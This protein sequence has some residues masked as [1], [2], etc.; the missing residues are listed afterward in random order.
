[1]GFPLK[2]MK[3]LLL[4]ILIW[5]VAL[6]V[7]PASAQQVALCD[8][9]I[10]NADG[11]WTATQYARVQ[12]AGRS[13]PV[14][15]GATFRPGASF[16]GIDLAEQLDKEC[17]A[18]VQRQIEEAKQVDVQTYANPTTGN[19]DMQSMTC[20][21][22]TG[23]HPEDS[24]FLALWLSGWSNGVAKSQVVNVTKIRTGMRDLLAYC[25]AN[26]DKKVIQANKEL[27]QAGR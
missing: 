14:N 25:K 26:P 18:A 1:M 19:I 22:L 2:N 7:V 20:G 24:E 21:Q 5:P 23:T 16:A 10:K 17:P 4:T 12:G 13:L 8:S 6:S 15:V 27:I 3:A 11:S 9:F